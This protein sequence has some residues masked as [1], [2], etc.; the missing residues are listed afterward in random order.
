MIIDTKLD[1][2]VQCKWNTKGSVLAL[3]GMSS[4][5]QSNGESREVTV[6]NFYDAHG[7]FLRTLKVCGSANLAVRSQVL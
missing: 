2:L 6:V 7:V 4:H 3:A 5:T 1:P